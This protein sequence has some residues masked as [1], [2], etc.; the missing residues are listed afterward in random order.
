MQRGKDMA[1][2]LPGLF[3]VHHNLPSSV[4][5]AHAHAEHHLIIPLQGEVSVDLADRSFSCGPGRMIYVS[6]NTEHSFR[7]AKDKGERLICM[8]DAAPWQK[9]DAGTFPSAM[10]PASQLCKELLFQLL[11]KPKSKNTGALID[12]FIRT[13][14]EILGAGGGEAKFDIDLAEG[15]VKRPELRKA[16]AIA[17][18]NFTTEL[19][20][21]ALARQSGLSVRNLSRLCQ[22]ELALTPKQI[23]V[24]LKI[25]KAAEH[26][27]AGMTVTETAYAVGYN[28]LSQF[29]EA[30]RQI[31]GQIPSAYV[32]K[33]HRLTWPNPIGLRGQIPSWPK[34]VIRWPNTGS[35]KNPIC[36]KT[37]FVAK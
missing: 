8:I 22:L 1:T 20:V 37:E 2:K 6:P 9:A 27:A 33:S 3:L 35:R 18:A 13:L 32:A 29:I 12:V 24:A 15:R 4:V 17:R 5:A 16:L 19:S 36:G 25:E 34:T 28:S 7:S 10:L 31:T 30:F 23:L 14:D 21:A 11:L 26:L